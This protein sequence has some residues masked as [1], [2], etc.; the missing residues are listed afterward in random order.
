MPAPFMVFFPFHIIDVQA[1]VHYKQT[2]YSLED[3]DLGLLASWDFLNQASVRC[4]GVEL[5]L[6]VE[7]LFQAVHVR[8]PD[9]RF[10][11]KTGIWRSYLADRWVNIDLSISM[12]MDSK[13]S[14][15]VTFWIS[16]L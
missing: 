10:E 3:L 13:R 2:E 5:C 14:I 8:Q 9:L 15:I 16:V 7:K 12:V 6:V 4:E 11:K 1:S